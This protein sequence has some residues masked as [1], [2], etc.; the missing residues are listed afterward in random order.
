[1]RLRLTA[2]S[3]VLAGFLFL[4][5]PAGATTINFY[6]GV[7]DH[8]SL[9]IN[10]SS[11]VNLNCPGSC[12]GASLLTLPGGWYSIVITYANY[13]GSTN[14]FFSEDPALGNNFQ[15]VPLS[16]LRSFD[17]SGNYIQ[18]LRAD[19][20][21]AVNFTGFLGTV[22]GEGPIAHGYNAGYPYW[23][24]GQTNPINNPSWGPF[25]PDAGWS[26]FSERLTGEIYIPT[27]VPEPTA[28][29]LL[30]T[31]LAAVVALRRRRA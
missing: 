13:G 22:Y 31:G 20:Y 9:T 19:Y 3:T 2:L 26:S 6:L 15:T 7:D 4:A 23:Y 16:R 18:G 14:L 30:G 29:F 12:S 28:L 8:G 17:A 5:A 27:A 11:L 25:I 24:Q 10:G 1:M 21:S